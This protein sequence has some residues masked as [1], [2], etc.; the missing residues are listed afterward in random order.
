MNQLSKLSKGDFVNGLPKLDFKKNKLC[1]TC[2]FGKQY[3]SSFKSKDMIST[4]KHFELIHI[5]LF[6][7]SRTLSLGGK[8]NDPN[9][10]TSQPSYHFFL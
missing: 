10:V 9:V 4:T 7:P 8:C 2:Q 3:R 6:C 5:D 1:D